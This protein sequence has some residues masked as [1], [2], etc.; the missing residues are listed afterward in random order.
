MKAYWEK[1][2]KQYDKYVAGTWTGKNVDKML[3]EVFRIKAQLIDKSQY[4]A[5]EYYVTKGYSG[6]RFNKFFARTSKG[7]IK[8]AKNISSELKQQFTERIFEDVSEVMNDDFQSKNGFEYEVSART[9]KDITFTQAEWSI[10]QEIAEQRRQEGQSFRDS[11]YEVL[12][13]VSNTFNMEWDFN[14]IIKQASKGDGIALMVSKK[15]IDEQFMN[16]YKNSTASVIDEALETGDTHSAAEKMVSA[17]QNL[18]FEPGQQVTGKDLINV[19]FNSPTGYD[20]LVELLKNIKDLN[21]K[22]GNK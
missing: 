12:K 22:Y 9:G 10:I 1:R 16:L 19:F 11:L 7:T 2:L 3:E 17:A 18:G 6:N 20:D 8:F 14:S 5:M 4:E 15:L 21:D 13:Q